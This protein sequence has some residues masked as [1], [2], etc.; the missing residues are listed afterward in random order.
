[1]GGAHVGVAASLI[2]CT[3]DT[4]VIC[5][6]P[7]PVTYGVLCENM[8]KHSQRV[9]LVNSAISDSDCQRQLYLHRGT[10]S[11]DVVRPNRLFFSS[12]FASRP[13]QDGTLTINCIPLQELVDRFDP[14]VLKIDAEGA[15]C[16]ILGLTDFRRIRLIVAE[17][18]WTHNRNRSLWDAMLAHLGTEFS[19]KVKGRMPEFDDA[20]N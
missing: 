16:F 4:S 15:E 2:L 14:T 10:N 8:A 9:T 17:W 20:G 12:L 18:D 19:V 6:E 3:E 7:H 1:M 5:V 11:G 13:H